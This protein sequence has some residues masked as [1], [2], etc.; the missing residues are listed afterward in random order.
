MEKHRSISYSIFGKIIYIIIATKGTCWW[1]SNKADRVDSLI[2][3]NR[4]YFRE[5]REYS[6]S[7]IVGRFVIGIAAFK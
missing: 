2:A 3:L 6:Y 5:Y 4:T 1:H 7:L